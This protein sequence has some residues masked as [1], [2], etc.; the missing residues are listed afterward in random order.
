MGK[1]YE[2]ASCGLLRC[3]VSYT[4]Q[5]YFLLSASLW[6]SLAILAVVLWS[7]WDSAHLTSW[8]VGL[9]FIVSLLAPNIADV[10][11][12]LAW[13][14]VAGPSFRRT[15]GN[16]SPDSLLSASDP[17][18]GLSCLVLLGSWIGL[19]TYLGWALNHEASA[20]LEA[21]GTLVLVRLLLPLGWALLFT[22]VLLV[23]R[24]SGRLDWI[25]WRYPSILNAHG[26]LS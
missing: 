7:L 25:I 15:E 16:V 6:S 18:I 1:A 13:H 22:F 24:K 5:R 14:D 9:G 19:A 8:A 26:I 21:A 10:L 20:L 17:P 4:L 23:S 12:N 3:K 11:G 2:Y